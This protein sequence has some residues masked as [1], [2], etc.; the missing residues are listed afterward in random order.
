MYRKLDPV[1]AV[2]MKKVGT[3]DPEINKL[4]AAAAK[5]PKVELVPNT[6]KK[7]DKNIGGSLV[8]GTLE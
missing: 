6:R 4:V 2:V 8:Q 5:K 1:S 3:D 7:K